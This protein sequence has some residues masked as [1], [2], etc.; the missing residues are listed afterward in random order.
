MPKFEAKHKE[1]R[2]KYRTKKLKAKAAKTVRSSYG[3]IVPVPTYENGQPIVNGSYQVF[4]RTDN[5]YILYD[6]SKPF[7]KNTVRTFSQLQDA[8]YYIERLVQNG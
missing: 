3:C 1:P 7:G 8:V 5:I 4:R 2:K 6:H